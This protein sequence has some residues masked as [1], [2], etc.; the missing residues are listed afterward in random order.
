[1]QAATAVGMMPAM[2]LEGDLARIALQEERLR[3]PAFAP[4]DAW[5][6]GLHLQRMA[7]ALRAPVA[8]DIS[9]VS[10]QLFF[11]ALEGSVPDNAE[12]IR[13]KR[14]V[15]FRFFRSSYG[16]TLDL[17]RRKTDL[18]TRY[19][20]ESRDYTASGGSFPIHVTGTGVIG[21]ITVSGLPQREDHGLVVAALAE[22]LGA[23]AAELA[24]DAA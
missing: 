16:V 2:S 10:R 1:L 8:I 22:T 23:D 15:V 12:W 7:A 19:G 24:L 4:G 5:N 14:N 13:R 20:L 3:F 6:L 21:A 17:E 11:V 18:L 9:A